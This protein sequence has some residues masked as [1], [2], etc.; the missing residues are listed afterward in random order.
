[1]RVLLLLFLGYG[2]YVCSEDSNVLHCIYMAWLM[3]QIDWTCLVAI[4]DWFGYVSNDL[5]A[6]TEAKSCKSH[7][8]E[9]VTRSTITQLA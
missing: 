4:W 1:M 7:L 6:C 5:C 9:S 2:Q 3:I 8:S